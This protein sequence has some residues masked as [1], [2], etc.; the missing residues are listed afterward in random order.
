MTRPA[1][2]FVVYPCEACGKRIFAERAQVGRPGACPLCRAAHTVG[3]RPA[4]VAQP[5]VERRVAP[6]V[7]PPEGEVALDALRTAGGFVALEPRVHALQDLSETGLSW[8]M[9]AG[10]DAP[11]PGDVLRLA[12][13]VPELLRP[14]TFRAEVRRVTPSGD[15][16]VTVGLA[17]IDVAQDQAGELRALVRRLSGSS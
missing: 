9:A 14:R 5:G 4:P 2:D 7:A 16:A 1:A 3:G 13:Q 6:R 11:R 10:E 12:L 15:G 17:F 8:Q